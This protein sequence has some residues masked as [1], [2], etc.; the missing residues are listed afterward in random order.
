MFMP[1]GQAIN[2][3]TN[4]NWDGIGVIPDVKVPMEVALD[5]AH[6]MASPSFWRLDQKA[7]CAAKWKKPYPW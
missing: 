4:G 5:T 7:P 2:P 3:V 1:T 6:L